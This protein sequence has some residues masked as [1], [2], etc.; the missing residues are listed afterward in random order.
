[1]HKGKLYPTVVRRDLNAEFIFPEMLPR[2]WVYSFDDWLQSTFDPDGARFSA[3]S[4]NDLYFSGKDTI[5]WIWFL[6]NS[7]GHLYIIVM[8]YVIENNGRSFQWVLNYQDDFSG[9]S[10]VVRFRSSRVQAMPFAYPIQFDS[11]IGGAVELVSVVNVPP[12]AFTYSGALPV[13]RLDANLW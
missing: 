7:D 5:N 3:V 12:Y 10:A 9:G 13:I 8:Y 4:T 2:A 11:S 1:V 6:P